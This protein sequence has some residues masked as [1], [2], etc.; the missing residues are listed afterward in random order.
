[1]RGLLVLPLHYKEGEKY[2]LIIDIHGGD[3][4][5]N[6]ILAGGI[7]TSSPLEWQL[8]AAK[9]YAV[10][11]PEFRSSATFGYLAILRDQ[12]Q[13]HDIINCD[14]IDVMAGLDE[15]VRHGIV[16]NNRVAVIGHSAGGRRANW[17]TVSTKRFRV[18][19]S[20]EGWADE[21]AVA[22]KNPLV[23]KQFGGS[24]L[25]VPENYLRN[26]P[27]FHSKDAS[28]P[29]LFLMGNP[30]LGGVD[31]DKTVQQLY[32][33]LK[34]QGVKT[35]YIEYLDEGHTFGLPKNRQDALKRTIEWI[36]HYTQDH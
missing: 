5:A 36:D 28:T 33:T 30:N 11:V 1:M 2:P 8:W 19:I 12:L 16:D 34:K 31:E 22:M 35:E 32:E 23:S 10:F 4:G 6:I 17:L 18:V 24:P 13:A 20:K 29:T 9:G 25:E 14:I 27:L 3:S 26:S 15:L 21:R 7:L